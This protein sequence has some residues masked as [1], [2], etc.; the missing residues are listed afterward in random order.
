MPAVSG[1]RRAR[2]AATMRAAGVGVAAAGASSR[3]PAQVVGLGAD[4]RHR[5]GRRADQEAD[6]EV[7]GRHAERAGD[8]V[9]VE[10]QRLVLD[11][12]ARGSPTPRSPRAAPRRAAI[13]RP[14]RSARRAGSS[15][16]T[17]GC[18]VSST[19]SPAASSTSADA[20][21]WPGHAGAGAGVVGPGGEEGEERLP[22]RL[23]AGGRRRASAPQLGGRGG[24]GYHSS[25]PSAGSRGGARRERS[26]GTPTATA[27]SGC[28]SARQVQRPAHD[29]RREDRRPDP[30]RRQPLGGQRHQ[31]RLHGG[32]AGDG[33]H[34]PLADPPRPRRGRRACRR[35]CRKASTSSGARR[36]SSPRRIRRATSSAGRPSASRSRPPARGHRVQQR[37]APGGVAQPAEPERRAV[38]RRR[39]GQRH[40]DGAAQR[41][42][43]HRLRR[44]TRGCCAAA[45]PPRGGPGRCASSVPSQNRSSSSGRTRSRAVEPSS[46]GAHA[47]HHRDR[48]PRRACPS[49]GPRPPASSSASGDLGDQQL[50]ALGVRRAPRSGAAPA[51]RPSRWRR[52]SARPASVRPI[53]SVTTHGD[54]DAEPARAAP[55]AAARRWRPGRPAAGPARRG[56]RWTRRPRP[57]PARC[58]S[59]FGTIR[60]RPR[61]ASTRSDSASTSSRRSA[62]R[63][64]GSVGRRHQP[65]LH[66]GHDLAGDRR[67]TSPSASQGAAS[68]R[69]AARSSPGRNSGSPRHAAGR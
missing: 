46:A 26:R 32:P 40:P 50:V 38:V 60:V 2:A 44:R 22:Q 12:P 29:V 4:R 68:A 8:R 16:P 5:A 53:V 11:G 55:R 33:E 48:Q 57:R 18:R 31:Q 63:A 67:R 14:A 37:G 15:G 52:R 28:Q 25:S 69:A 35:R 24:R 59:L 45:A 62:S 9:H 34:R 27:P 36:S 56:A 54:V 6:V 66:L 7:P 47:A 43:V 51:A 30:A 23:L 42:R 13:G 17:R 19:R 21:R 1:W 61:R 39:R 41:L 3:P 64:S 58:P 10:V 65:A 20:V 49:P